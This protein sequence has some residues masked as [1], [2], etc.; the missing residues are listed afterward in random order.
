MMRQFPFRSVSLALGLVAMLVF[1]YDIGYE[2]V[3]NFGRQVP[4]LYFIL[5][6][7]F[8]FFNIF[9][10][11]TALM[12][13]S[14]RGQKSMVLFFTGILLYLF[15]IVL[16]QGVPLLVVLSQNMIVLR[17]SMLVF[18]VI[19]YS[20]VIERFYAL[21]M[22]PA[23]VFAVSF[24]ILISIGTMLLMLPLANEKDISFVDALFTATS[25]VCVTGLAVLDTGKDFTFVGQVII[26]SL[27]QAGGLGMLT[28]T[29][30]FAYFF[31]QNLSYRESLFL[32][33]F[34]STNRL[35]NIFQLLISIVAL[36][37]AIEFIGALFIFLYLPP[38]A[39]PT[40]GERLFF[41]I[42]H[43]ISA[44]CNAG[45]S[46]LSAG[47]YDPI[48]RH[49]YTVQ[50]VICFL[51][52]LGGLGY[53]IVF[54]LSEYVLEKVRRARKRL[55]LKESEYRRKVRIVKLNSKIVV[56][57]TVILLVFGTIFFFFSERTNILAEHGTW[58]GKLVT[59]FFGSV[60]PRT[61][62][63]N[64]FD[65]GSMQVSTIM[66]MLLLMWIGA[67]PGSTGGG[68]KTSTFAIA[69]LVIF[70]TAKGKDRLELANR[71]VSNYSLR[72]AFSII[73]LSLIF[74]GLGV[75]FISSFE[76]EGKAEF[77]PIAFECFSAY[78]TVGLSM[79]LT[80]LLTEESRIVLIFLMFI[81]RVG[82]I[83][84]LIG[85]LT[86]I[87]AQHLRYP[88]EDILIN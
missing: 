67:S 4:L 86:Q 77:L 85:I 42:F 31:K 30:F 17:I 73:N 22:Q 33:D 79:N 47:L 63:F 39:F 43:S 21:K 36:T 54:N 53:N 80:P 14:R 32:R 58:W 37:A 35:G 16:L 44:F 15:S 65:V 83:N 1:I 5:L 27:I 68:I 64:T 19:E 70:S 34:I 8:I 40:F 84:L 25:A 6:S 12:H 76:S 60:T 24:F 13:T 56:Y 55:F 57:T 74:I 29:S 10:L 23:F 50:L 9:R 48:V 82:A 75:F 18:F 88:E 66:V 87:D 49:S 3:G 38:D 51:I 71:V 81:G 41:S 46:T 11:L 61:A 78:S 59:A 7:S 72:R 28:L 62:G 26:L 2:D 69:T 20:I 52:I 45:F